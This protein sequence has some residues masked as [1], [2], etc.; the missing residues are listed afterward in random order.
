MHL[1]SM[2]SKLSIFVFLVCSPFSLFAQEST[3]GFT[4]TVKHL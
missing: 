2:K 3:S 1:S 4:D